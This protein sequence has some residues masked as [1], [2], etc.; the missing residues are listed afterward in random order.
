MGDEGTSAFAQEAGQVLD[1]FKLFEITFASE[2]R[3][4]TPASDQAGGI[5][6]S[7]AKIHGPHVGEGNDELWAAVQQA[8]RYH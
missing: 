5:A 3:L 8:P 4:S 2:D 1:D 6:F 7:I